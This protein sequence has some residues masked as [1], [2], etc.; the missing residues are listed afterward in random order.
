MFLNFVNFPTRF[1]P[2]LLEETYFYVLLGPDSH[3]NY[4]FDIF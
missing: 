4:T 1:R 3:G 2:R